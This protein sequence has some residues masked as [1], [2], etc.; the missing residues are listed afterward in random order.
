MILKLRYNIPI[1]Y[2][3]SYHKVDA[4]IPNMKSVFGIGVMQAS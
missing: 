4:T 1:Y 3:Y 2:Q